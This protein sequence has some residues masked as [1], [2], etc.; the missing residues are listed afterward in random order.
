MGVSLRFEVFLKWKIEY[1]Q[2]KIHSE[3]TRSIN[4]FDHLKSTKIKYINELNI[5]GL[6][7]E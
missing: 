2:V 6:N 1:I 3:K 7:I 4:L 5:Y